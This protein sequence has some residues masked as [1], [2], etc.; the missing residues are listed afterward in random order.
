MENPSPHSTAKSGISPS[1]S[2]TSHSNS[3][4]NTPTTSASSKTFNTGGGDSGKDASSHQHRRSPASD[5]GTVSSS[6]EPLAGTCK[7]DG[8]YPTL[9]MLTNAHVCDVDQ[10]LEKLKVSSKRGLS[11]GEASERLHF[12]GKNELQ[13]E[14]GK[15]IFQLI[16]E[17]FQDLLVRILLLAAVVSFVLALFEGDAHAEGITAFIEPLVILVI[18]I[19]NAAVGVWQ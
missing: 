7:K 15:S 11:D 13:H 9:K 19:L 16:L 6:P 3:T 14:P 17:Q 8:R 5:C 12:F 10:V 1:S 4:I 2:T 18:L